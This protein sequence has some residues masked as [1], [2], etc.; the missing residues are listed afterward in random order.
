MAN[1]EEL[2][3]AVISYN[4]EQVKSL[5]KKL[6]ESGTDPVEVINQ[7]LIDGMSVV[8]SRFKSGELFLPEVMLAAKAMSTGMDIAKQYLGSRDVPTSG[9]VVIGTVKGDLHD[10][11]KNLVA[12]MLESTGFKVVDLG[13]DVAPEKFV[14]AVKEYNPGVIGMSALL[15]VTMLSMKDTLELL[16]EEG[17]RSKVKVMIGGAPISQEFAD[18]IGADGFALDAASA[19]ELCKK[20]MV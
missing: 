17:L 16:E 3:A 13:V 19:A 8:G 1:F 9:I 2:S 11:G 12:M 10:I 20:L 6:V 14:A 18:E 5:V 15:T 7:G 4:A